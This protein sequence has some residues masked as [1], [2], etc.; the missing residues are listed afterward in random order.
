[1]RSV[2]SKGRIGRIMAFHA[3]LQTEA[4]FFLGAPQFRLHLKKPQCRQALGKVVCPG[5]AIRGRKQQS[6][7]EKKSGP[8]KRVHFYAKS[9]TLI[10]W[11]IPSEKRL[12][13]T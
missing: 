3:P 10:T 2:L 9:H 8:A 1:A 11:A 4:V 5:S 6:G 7:N 12:V 13:Y